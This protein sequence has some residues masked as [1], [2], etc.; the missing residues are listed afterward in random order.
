[1]RT[2]TDSFRTYQQ[3]LWIQTASDEDIIEIG[4]RLEPLLISSK[5]ISSGSCL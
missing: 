4:S 1:M 5:T 2:A 3:R